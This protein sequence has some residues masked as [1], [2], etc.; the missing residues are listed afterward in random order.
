[1]ALAAAAAGSSVQLVARVVDDATGDAMLQDLTSRG[2]AHVATLRQPAGPEAPVLEAADLELALRYLTDVGVAGRGAGARLGL[3]AVAVDAAAW[4]HAAL[5][6]IV[7]ADAAVPPDLPDGRDRPRRR[8]MP[9]PDGA[10][11]SLVG[12]YAA[13]LD[14][15]V[16]AG[17]GFQT[18]ITAARPGRLS[19]TDVGRRLEATAS[20]AGDGRPA[21]R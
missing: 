12:A 17:D 5:V 7:R 13:A 16:D 15:G 11:G 20:S 14:R 1:M 6:V 9:I 19:T 21:A 2:V 3:T 8:P 4:N 18:T 10:F